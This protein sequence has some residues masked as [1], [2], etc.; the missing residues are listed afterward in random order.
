MPAW[1]ATLR[2]VVAALNA[3]VFLSP[4]TTTTG[5]ARYTFIRNF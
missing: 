3:N 5:R 4:S 2:G 1:L